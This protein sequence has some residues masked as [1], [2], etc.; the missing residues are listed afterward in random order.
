MA[1]EG[2]HGRHKNQ[3]T[4]RGVETRLRARQT[5]LW[6]DR[7]AEIHSRQKDTVRDNTSRD[8]K[9]DTHSG[10]T[11]RPTACSGLQSCRWNKI[12]F[13]EKGRDTRER[14]K[15]RIGRRRRQ[16]IEERKR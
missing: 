11:G 9:T 7:E 10:Q 2:R 4:M 12:K 16:K 8:T 6:R 1:T 13:K 14:G 3:T 15:A 5:R